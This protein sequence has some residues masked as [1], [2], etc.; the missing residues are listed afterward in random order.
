MAALAS[1]WF[2]TAAAQGHHHHHNFAADVD[3]FHAVL[4]PLW[5][6]RPGEARSRNAC[7]KAGQL[8]ALARDIRSTDA[9]ALQA[10]I[11]A[12][13]GSCKGKLAGVDGALHDVH[14]AFHRLIDEPQAA[15]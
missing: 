11:A 5:H 9:A 6:S 1:L 8:A 10:S 14:E 15:K 2:G 7:A 3:A 12:L 13:K 4:A